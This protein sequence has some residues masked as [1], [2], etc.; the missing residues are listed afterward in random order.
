MEIQ[1]Q[2][3]V[4]VVALVLFIFNAYCKDKD[5]SRSKLHKKIDKTVLKAY[6]T[7]K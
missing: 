5:D 6:G 3:F 1:V 4:V 7:S 2:E